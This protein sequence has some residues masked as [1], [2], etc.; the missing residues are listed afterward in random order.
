MQQNK[1]LHLIHTGLTQINC[2]VGPSVAQ[3][4]HTPHIVD[5]R[6]DYVETHFAGHRR[7]CRL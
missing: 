7:I 1:G 2:R 4:H 5:G 3:C 6:S